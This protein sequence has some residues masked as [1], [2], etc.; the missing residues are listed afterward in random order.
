MKK[1]VMIPFCSLL[2]FASCLGG[3]DPEAVDLEAP[4][5][6][7]NP[8]MS[9]VQPH[10][11][12]KADATMSE[13]PLAFTVADASGIREIKIESHSGFDGHTHGKSAAARNLKFKLFNHNEVMGAERFDD[14][15]RFSLSSSI[16]LDERNP[17]LEADE[18][19][20]GGPYH[21]SIQ[22]T[23]MEG[24][25]TTYRD[26][27]TY[28]TTLYLNRP[29][30]PQVALTETGLSP[31]ALNG[32][33][34]RNMAHGASSDIGFLWIYTERPNTENPAQEGLVVKERIWGQSN[35]PHQSRSNSGDPLPHSRELSLQELLGLDS[36]FLE[37][38]E[39]G[40][41]LVIWAEDTNGNISVHQFNI[42]N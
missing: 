27:T 18:L 20:L 15:E 35:W 37:S 17:E 34:F 39:A 21:F 22:A 13:I 24:N 5:I 36:D 32:R 7:A 2:L 11:F 12:F 29:Y 6:M 1:R 8:G 33:I 25:E 9:G 40:N 31:T 19:I 30:A 26:G 4:E 14:P 3:D 42:N 10:Y 16:Y 28:H 23:D 41:R 38:L